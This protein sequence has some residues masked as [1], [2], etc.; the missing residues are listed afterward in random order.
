MF[1]FN[2]RTANLCDYTKCDEFICDVHGNDSLYIE[3]MQMFK[4]LECHNM[5][6][7]RQ[8]LEHSTNAYGLPHQMVEFCQNKQFCFILNG[9]LDLDAPKLLQMISSLQVLEFDALFSDAHCPLAIQI[10]KRNI[11]Q[12]KQKDNA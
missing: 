1:D 12:K 3:N 8:N 6:L 9:R 4:R 11:T 2:S 5:P 10:D 7:Q